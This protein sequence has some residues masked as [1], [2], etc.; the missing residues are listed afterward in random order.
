MSIPATPFPPSALATT[1]L[2]PLGRG[3]EIGPAAH[4]PFK[5]ANCL[6]MDF[7]L[8]PQSAPRGSARADE[9]GVQPID[10]LAAA[11]RLPFA[12]AS[13][14]Y[15][16]SSHVIEHV[17]DTIAALKE[18][19][20]VLRPSGILFMIVPH[21]L[22]TFD[23]GRPRTTFRE[24]AERHA[25]LRKPPEEAPIGGHYSVWATEDLVAVC[26]RLGLRIEQI[27]DIDDKV[28][29]GFTLVLR[30]GGRARPFFAWRWRLAKELESL[31]RR[32]VKIV[33]PTA[34]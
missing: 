20:R 9:P 18:W 30:K 14:D 11:D 28:G 21:H 2:S 22:R 6:F 26:A 29:N 33:R 16:L 32:A 31:S 7:L 27:Q 23:K 1:L 10:L 13:L 12:D 25:G 8:G 5:L 17:F 4:N 15:V 19:L 34:A 24:L 3:I